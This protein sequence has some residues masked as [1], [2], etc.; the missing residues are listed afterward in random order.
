[1]L[2]SHYK[3]VVTVILQDE[4]RST[5]TSVQLLRPLANW[6]CGQAVILYATFGIKDQ[7]SAGPGP[8]AGSC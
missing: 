8:E 1:M 3:M 2:L 6:Q 5:R 4:T 7:A